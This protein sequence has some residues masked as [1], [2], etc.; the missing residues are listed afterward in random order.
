MLECL[1]FI[2]STR[3]QIERALCLVAHDIGSTMERESLVGDLLLL[4]SST[5]HRALRELSKEDCA[6][7]KEYLLIKAPSI[8]GLCLSV[9]LP[10]IVQEGNVFVLVGALLLIVRAA[11]CALLEAS[12]DPNSEGDR[13]MV[14]PI[15]SHWMGYFKVSMQSG[16]SQMVC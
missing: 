1:F 7:L 8:H 10:D 12:L 13:T 3:V 14:S 2:P 15:C 5:M 11:L 4:L 16:R 9:G 6:R